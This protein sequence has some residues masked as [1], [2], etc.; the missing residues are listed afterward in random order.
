[1]F[2]LPFYPKL[3]VRMCPQGIKRVK[4]NAEVPMIDDSMN[5]IMALPTD[6]EFHWSNR[7]SKIEQVFFDGPR[8]GM[9]PAVGCG[10]STQFA[11][12]AWVDCFT[13]IKCHSTTVKFAH[14]FLSARLFRRSDSLVCR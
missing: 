9:M 2:S 14:Q 13:A 11:E 12:H 6:V 1:M 3:D 4:F 8:N 10:H 7:L 5:N